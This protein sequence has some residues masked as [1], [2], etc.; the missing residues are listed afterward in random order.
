MASWAMPPQPVR[1]P[2]VGSRMLRRARLFRR[3]RR[4]Y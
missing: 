4:R 2:S 1:M 3:R